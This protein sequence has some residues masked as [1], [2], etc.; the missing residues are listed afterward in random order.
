MSTPPTAQI[1][2]V[3]LADASTPASAQTTAVA[4]CQG[5]AMR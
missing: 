1:Q 4:A 3:P 5:A 2:D